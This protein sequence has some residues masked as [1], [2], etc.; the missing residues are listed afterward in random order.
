[1]SLRHPAA[2][3]C[4]LWLLA[5]A[6][7]HGIA[8][9]PLT[10]AAVA[11]RQ[12]PEDARLV[13]PRGLNDFGA[14]KAHGKSAG[15][16]QSDQAVAEAAGPLSDPRRH[17]LVERTDTDTFNRLAQLQ[18]LVDAGS[19][20]DA[21]ALV[22]GWDAPW[23]NRLAPHPRDPERLVSLRAAL[24]EHLQRHPPLK[25]ALTQD[26]AEL[27]RLRVAQAVERRDVARLRFAAIQFAG[28]EAAALA[29]L[30]LGDQA[31]AAGWF[32]SAES[33]YL[34]GRE[35]ASGATRRALDAR[36]RLAAAMQGRDAGT[37]AQGATEIAGVTMTAEAFESLVAEMLAVHADGNGDASPLGRP[38]RHELPPPG[39]WRARRHE[40]PSGEAE[41]PSSTDNNSAARSRASDRQ[42][43][44]W[45]YRLLGEQVLLSDGLQVTSFSL[46]EGHARWQAALPGSKGPFGDRAVVSTM[47]LV[48]SDRVFVRLEIG[49]GAVLACFDRDS[50][51]LLWST[52]EG[53][54][55]RIVSGPLLSDGRA[56]VLT[57]RGQ[58]LRQSLLEWRQIQLDTGLLHSPRPLLT[59][60]EAD[61]RD[62]SVRA[63]LHAERLFVALEGVLLCC[64]PEGNVLWIR[65]QSL[66]PGERPD[67]APYHVQAPRVREGRVF[68]LL[69]SSDTVECTDAV[70]GRHVW[71]RA[72]PGIQR[73]LGFSG[74]NLI[75]QTQSDV[76]ALRVS[77]GEESWRY[78]FENALG[79]FGCDRRYVILS[80]HVPDSKDAPSHVPGLVWIRAA[81]GEA[82]ATYELPP[83]ESAAT[84]L[85]PMWS[86]G[87]HLWLLYDSGRD[88]AKRELIELVPEGRDE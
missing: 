11:Q 7:P 1:M 65:Q 77:D 16:S 24:E 43:R 35:S 38:A 71:R 62:P 19:W 20:D 88:G 40:F 4:S 82:L 79:A 67:G 22:R 83:C 27:A 54:E 85:G 76:L 49:G 73:V 81:D 13:Q 14:R 3:L 58:P 41:S 36:L 66:P 63:T 61:S 72:L 30:W 12:S 2:L 75:V 42:E 34:R 74:P 15:G 46:A 17:P 64:D 48:V 59:L 47:P 6:T 23:P 39:T 29:H 28:T 33:D 84:R 26:Y 18:D 32:G 78:R 8:A 5:A 80:R 68:G 56:F 51:D 70:A 37:T 69:A 52:P 10:P 55:D 57:M 50:G 31:L 86:A 21:G 53:A 25:H 45:Q 87:G 44:S 60:R 9:E